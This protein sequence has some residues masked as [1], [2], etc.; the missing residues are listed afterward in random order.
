M[1][2]HEMARRCATMME[3]LW[4]PYAV[5]E[6]FQK[7]KVVID[8]PGDSRPGYFDLCGI[9]PREDLTTDLSRTSDDD[10][11]AGGRR[12]HR[13]AREQPRVPRMEVIGRFLDQSSAEVAEQRVGLCHQGSLGRVYDR[14]GHVRPIGASEA[15]RPRERSATWTFQAIGRVAASERVRG[16]RRGR[17]P[18]A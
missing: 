16:V 14:Q 7:A 4:R 17:S 9:P 15:T 6:L 8:E 18:P 2:S 11:E 5:D 12:H 1:N 13:C 10:V 3:N